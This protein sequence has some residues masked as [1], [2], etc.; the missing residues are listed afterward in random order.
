MRHRGPEDGNDFFK[1]I[2]K[3]ETESS[4]NICILKCVLWCHTDFAAVEQKKIRRYTGRKL[5]FVTSGKE[6]PRTQCPNIECKRGRWCLSGIQNA[7]TLF[8]RW[9]LRGMK[10][11]HLLTHSTN[12]S[13]VCVES[14]CIV[15]VDTGHISQ[16][17]TQEKEFSFQRQLEIY[18]PIITPQSGSKLI[19]RFTFNTISNS[20]PR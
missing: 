1:V 14:L 8:S 17:H 9:Q 7:T 19:L 15:S 13:V 2:S 10:I 18:K 3:S 16:G 4:L 20:I 12:N 5:K 6:G 11:G